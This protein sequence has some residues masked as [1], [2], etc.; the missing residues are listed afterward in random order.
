VS[1]EDDIDLVFLTPELETNSITHF[2]IGDNEGN[3]GTR[4]KVL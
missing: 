4:K 1:N 2:S 3:T